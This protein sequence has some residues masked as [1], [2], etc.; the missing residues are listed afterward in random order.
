MLKC[1]L[2]KCLTTFEGMWLDLEIN[3]EDKGQ[4]WHSM[5]TCSKW[6]EKL[7][8]C[9]PK[10]SCPVQNQTGLPWMFHSSITLDVVPWETKRRSKRLF[11]RMSSSLLQFSI[12]L[13]CRI[14]SS[15]LQLNSHFWSTKMSHR[16]KSGNY[17]RKGTTGILFKSKHCLTL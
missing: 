6:I 1:T 9:N 4:M 8:W 2:S 11:I 15:S 16:A 5:P 13:L 3:T 14:K 12:D 7:T 10:C 17:E